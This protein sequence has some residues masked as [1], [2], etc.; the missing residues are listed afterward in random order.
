MYFFLCAWV[1]VQH[2]MRVLYLLK[3][4]R[5]LTELVRQKHIIKES[6]LSSRD[7]TSNVGVNI[8]EKWIMWKLFAVWI[9]KIDDWRSHTKPAP[10]LKYIK[11]T[12]CVHMNV[13][14]TRACGEVSYFE[15]RTRPYSII[16][17][18]TKRVECNWLV[19]HV[20]STHTRV[21][22]VP[23]QHIKTCCN[24]SLI[25][26][27]S[28]STS[29]PLSPLI[30]SLLRTYT[31]N[32]HRFVFVLKFTRIEKYFWLRSINNNMFCADVTLLQRLH[33]TCLCSGL[34]LNWHEHT[35]LGHV[36][37]GDNMLQF[38]S[39]QTVHILIECVGE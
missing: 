39:K 11:K 28:P 2:N 7:D 13:G 9:W 4:V 25:D 8:L 38:T 37:R 17:G 18:M 23:Y 24:F 32:V 36:N 19:L 27:F 22:N 29:H 16:P 20:R 33:S 34:T 15:R 35:N 6:F 21:C 3:I 10:T 30:I 5:T 12:F 31:D 14:R 26:V 1:R